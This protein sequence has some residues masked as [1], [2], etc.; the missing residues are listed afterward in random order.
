MLEPLLV[1]AL[2]GSGRF[3]A[4]VGPANG[5]LA[6]VRLHT[7]IVLLQQEFDTVPSRI[8]LAI[9]VQLI[10]LDTRA[11]LGTEL[12]EEVEDAPSEDAYGGVTATNIALERI[13][14]RT[15][16]LQSGHRPRQLVLDQ[17]SAL[18][19]QLQRQQSARPCAKLVA[20]G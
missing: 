4:V 8:R 14:S 1:E 3:S 18:S 6:D 17:L 16:L 9:R 7:E 20:R 19:S 11:V 5:G 13:L 15:S 2:E 10:D 12:M